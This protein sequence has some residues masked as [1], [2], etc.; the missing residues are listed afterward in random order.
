MDDDIF[1]RTNLVLAQN[2]N[3]AGLAIVGFE[4]LADPLTCIFL[5][6]EFG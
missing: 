3:I 5:G 4:E 1:G 2:S 6:G